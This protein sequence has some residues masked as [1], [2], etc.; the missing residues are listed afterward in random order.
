MELGT[1]VLHLVLEV[2]VVHGALA[3]VEVPPD[4]REGGLVSDVT[5]VEG[6]WYPVEPYFCW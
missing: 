2:L 5:N 1:R 4:G 3:C 6:F